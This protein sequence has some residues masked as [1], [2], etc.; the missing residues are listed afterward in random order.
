MFAWDPKTFLDFK[1]FRN[2]MLVHTL[3]SL[4]D[5]QTVINKQ[6]WKKVPPCLPIY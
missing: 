4:I 2:K 6:G 3:K 1:K 5:E